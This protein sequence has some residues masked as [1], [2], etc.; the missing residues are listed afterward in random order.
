MNMGRVERNSMGTAPTHYNQKGREEGETEK[1]RSQDTKTKEELRLAVWKEQIA[2]KTGAIK[3]RMIK[4][5]V[6]TQHSVEQKPKLK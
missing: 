1:K 5:R 4:K 2:L 3:K 6:R